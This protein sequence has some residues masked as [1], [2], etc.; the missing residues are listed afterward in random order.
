MKYLRIETDH[1]IPLSDSDTDESDLA[2]DTIECNDCEIE[3]LYIKH[4]DRYVS[5]PKCQQ[6]I[7]VGTK[8]LYKR[9]KFSKLKNKFRN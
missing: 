2:T 4:K 5:C 8:K 9:G 1:I 6:D 7:Y 3:I